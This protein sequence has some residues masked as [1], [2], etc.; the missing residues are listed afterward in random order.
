MHAGDISDLQLATIAPVTPFSTGAYQ[1]DH[2]MNQPGDE[3]G[4]FQARMHLAS[5]NFA[6][7]RRPRPSL[8]PN[9]RRQ[10]SDVLPLS[11][12]S[13]LALTEGRSGDLV[14]GS[15]VPR[16]VRTDE[17]V[18]PLIHHPSAVKSRDSVP[19]GTLLPSPLFETLIFSFSLRYPYQL[20]LRKSW[21]GPSALL[22]AA[23]RP[24]SP[25]SS[26]QTPV[27]HHSLRALRLWLKDLR[28]QR[29]LSSGEVAKPELWMAHTARNICAMHWS[30]TGSRQWTHIDTSTTQCPTHVHLTFKLYN[31][32]YRPGT[33]H[34]QTFLCR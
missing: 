33:L 10:K 32:P 3:P 24:R 1:I 13:A 30:W 28:S 25:K 29:G 22:L 5:E 16:A 7:S 18:W 2:V 12:W 23:L 9:P 26:V 8:R 27:S 31:Y 14:V 20:L 34:L 19:N 15:G 11:R 21:S 4:Y 6:C 17:T